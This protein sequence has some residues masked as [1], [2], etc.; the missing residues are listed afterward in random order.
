[1]TADRSP[2]ARRA[3]LRAALAAALAAVLAPALAACGRKGD[4]EPPPGSDPLYPRR[5]PTQ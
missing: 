5:Y 4:P 2:P 1:M 3:A